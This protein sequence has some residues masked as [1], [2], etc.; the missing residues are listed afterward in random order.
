MGVRPVCL[1]QGSGRAQRHNTEVCSYYSAV[2][3]PFRGRRAG[4]RQG[5]PRDQEASRAGP[6]TVKG[7][8]VAPLAV[9]LAVVARHTQRLESLGL[10]VVAGY[11]A[12]DPWRSTHA[13]TLCLAVGSIT[14]RRHSK[15]LICVADTP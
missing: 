9:P 7:G 5:A 12:V 13:S 2:S 8:A 3:S 14:A 1:P 15:L 6:G 4:T 10:A 11:A